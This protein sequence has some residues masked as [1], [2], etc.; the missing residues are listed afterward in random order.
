MLAPYLD[1]TRVAGYSTALGNAASFN[2][3]ATF[4]GGEVDNRGRTTGAYA[5]EF[6]VKAD[7]G[8]A[9]GYIFDPLGAAIGGN[10]PAIIHGFNTD[11]TELLYYPS[12]AIGFQRTGTSS[13]LKFDDG[14]WHH[15]VMAVNNDADL[16]TSD[17]V[18]IAVDGV[19]MT[20]YASLLTTEFD[21]TGAM[22]FGAC[23]PIPPGGDG[24]S[25]ASGPTAG[26]VWDGFH[27]QV[28]E[29][30][31]YDLAGMDST[32]VAAKVSSLASHYTLATSPTAI[33]PFAPVVAEE[34]SYSV[35]GGDPI[36]SS[37]DDSTG[38]ELSDA[39]YSGVYSLDGTVGFSGADTYTE[40][41]FDLSGTKTLSS[42][43]I[44]YIGAGGKWGIN[45]PAS[46]E[47]SF[48]TDGINFSDTVVF[49]DFNNAG[50]SDP[51]ANLWYERC[52]QVDVGS[53]DAQYVRA[54]FNHDGTFLFLSEVQLME[55]ISELIAGD[56]NNDGKVDGSD[57]TILAGNWQKGVSDGLTADWS[58][59]D[60]NGDG[61]VD[62]SDV[63]IL[64]GNWQYGVEAAAAAVPEPCTI[65]LLI[66]AFASLLIWRR[67]R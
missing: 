52:A 42:V 49:D 54:K 59:G 21:L 55:E 50:L 33:T 35:V 65:V 48:S 43:W 31:I 1:A 27:G 25:Y 9:A 4:W 32:A 64:A 57:V 58:E 29:F 19:V 62:G 61:K 40:L 56:A 26:G 37:Y 66:S 28:D 39:M 10:S 5:I 11:Y 63:T 30:A 12:S 18:D 14:Q 7:V 3:N 60:F 20:N 36:N 2:G 45:A 38:S 67:T 22:C 17:Q 53:I 34:V 16:N 8:A 47:L 13:D 46:V 15:V 41:E 24:G 51:E 6:W 44:S 23:K